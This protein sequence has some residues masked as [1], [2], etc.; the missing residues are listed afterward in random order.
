MKKNLVKLIAI[1]LAAVMLLSIAGVVAE[2]YI[3][4][5]TLRLP[6]VKSRPVETPVVVEEPVAEEPVVEEP[7]VEEPVVEEPVVEEPVVEEPVVEEPVVEEPVVEEPVVEEPV[8]EEPVVEEPVVEEPV[9]EEPVVEEPAVEEPVV[10]E[11]VVEEPVVEEPVVEEPA[12]PE[13]E[14]FVSSN[15]TNES[16]VTEGTELVLTLTVKGADGWLYRIQW[17]QT[18]DGVNWTDVPGANDHYFALKLKPE[19]SGMYWRAIVEIIG[20][21][22]AE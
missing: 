5:N 21:D 8:V 18:T 14:L 22:T 9:V 11:P 10:E 16:V 19:H 20:Q 17:Q 15:L 3:V 6:A 13:L 1:T 4:S 12:K 2:R 7:A